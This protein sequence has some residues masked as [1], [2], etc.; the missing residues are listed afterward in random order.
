M[1]APIIEARYQDNDVV[2]G[3]TYSYTV[4][5]VDD[6][7]PLPNVSEESNRVVETAR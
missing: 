5:A 2:P 4:V 6:R 7:L 1:S 3:V